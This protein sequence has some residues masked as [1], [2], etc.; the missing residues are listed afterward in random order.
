MAA[1]GKHQQETIDTIIASAEKRTSSGFQVDSVYEFSA[2]K[3]FDFAANIKESGSV[4]EGGSDLDKE[5]FGMKR[6]IF[7]LI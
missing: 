4:V 7:V 3:F 1:P 5:W 2:P 6:L